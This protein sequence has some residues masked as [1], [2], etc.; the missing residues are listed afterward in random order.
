MVRHTHAFHG[1]E[2]SNS[3]NCIDQHVHAGYGDTQAIIWESAVTGRK[4]KFTYAR[5]L[6]GVATLTGVLREDGVR[7]GDVV[8][9]YS[10][11]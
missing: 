11:Y 4:G 7:K 8:L 3:Y 6:E 5:V 1:G 10:M 2:I 9:I